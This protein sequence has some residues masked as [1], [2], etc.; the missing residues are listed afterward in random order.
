MLTSIQ[1]INY[2]DIIS[3]VIVIN[4][5]IPYTDFHLKL[6]NTKVSSMHMLIDSTRVMNNDNK[7]YHQYIMTQS[8]NVVTKY[9]D[10]DPG[11]SLS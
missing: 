8:T 11:R 5:K 1:K 9:L 2:I 6:A 3:I 10:C 4:D 7:Y